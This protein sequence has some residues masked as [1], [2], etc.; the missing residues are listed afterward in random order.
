MS[1]NQN[2]TE[3]DN[4]ML[5]EIMIKRDRPNICTIGFVGDLKVTIYPGIT[6][7]DNQEILKLIANKKHSRT[8]EDL[9]ESGV[10]K[11]V[12]VEILL[13]RSKQL[14]FMPWSQMML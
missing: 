3:K 12:R 14:S 7:I 10:H 9:I 5:P 8:W 1:N 11:I 6:R 4:K 13:R 2:Q